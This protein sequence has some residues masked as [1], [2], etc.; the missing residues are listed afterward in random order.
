MSDFVKILRYL[1]PF[2]PPSSTEYHNPSR[3]LETV[4]LVQEA[5]PISERLDVPAFVSIDGAALSGIVNGE[6]VSEDATPSGIFGVAF[7]LWNA[8]VSWVAGP[9]ATPQF[10]LEDQSG[11]L[12][13]AI[14]D[15]GALAAVATSHVSLS[16]TARGCLPFVVPHKYRL[17]CISVELTTL[18]LRY[19]RTV[20]QRGDHLPYF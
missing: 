14:G 5:V 6:F 4:Q 17:V 1:N 15:V 3:L 9:A 2:Y 7:V 8:S 11:T 10:F 12:R 20:I 18:R 13:T 19:I 16:V